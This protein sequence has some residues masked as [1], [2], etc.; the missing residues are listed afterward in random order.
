[1]TPLYVLRRLMQALIV[2]LGI[3]MVVFFLSRLTGDPVALL[4]G[5]ESGYDVTALEAQ[6]ALLRQKYGL[7][8]PLPVQY[9]KFVGNL[10][11][12]DLGESLW[13]KQST[14]SMIVERFPATVKL[15]VTA[16]ALSAII[17]GL[18]GVVAGVRR[19]KPVD[20][21]VMAI[22]LAGQSLPA[23]WLGILFILVF[24]VS[25]RW[26]PSSG[27]GGVRYL[28]LPAVTL[29]AFYM[30]RLARVT[31]ATVGDEMAQPYVVTARAKG[32]RES[33]VL[34]R[35]VLQ[36]AAI[37]MVT[38]VTLDLGHLLSGSV[39][40]ETIFAWPGVGFLI[41]Q[42]AYHRDFPLIQAA[43]IVVAVVI[44]AVNFMTDMIYTWLDPRIR[45]R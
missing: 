19:G 2:I 45:Y 21:V 41:A 18:I 30:A 32:L 24:A 11:R 34:L 40:V 1:M 8:Q 13:T 12:G 36:N 15:A 28:V 17:G 33:A 29:S 22:T 39:I 31:R 3:T 7:D 38:I 20:R 6:R 5:A 9:L 27:G 35:H 16:T 37:P 14:V 10:F 4:L 44:V 26:L 42:A 25:L 23:F 43:V